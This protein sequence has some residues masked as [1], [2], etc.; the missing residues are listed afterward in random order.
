MYN[1][2]KLKFGK[3]KLKQYTY[4]LLFQSFSLFFIV[5]LQKYE[6]LEK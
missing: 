3:K 2:N 6:T 1:I 5:E 4:I